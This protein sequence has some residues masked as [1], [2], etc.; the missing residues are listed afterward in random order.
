M[1]AIIKTSP[2]TQMLVHSIFITTVGD[3]SYFSGFTDE[4]TGPSLHGTGRADSQLLK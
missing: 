2:S 4:E 1:L 3:V